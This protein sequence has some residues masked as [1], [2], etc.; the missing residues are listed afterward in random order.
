M[1]TGVSKKTRRQSERQVNPLPQNDS[2]SGGTFEPVYCHEFSKSKFHQNF[3][4]IIPGVKAIRSWNR[5]KGS[6]L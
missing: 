4:K 5:S 3:V 1:V 2:Q 6:N